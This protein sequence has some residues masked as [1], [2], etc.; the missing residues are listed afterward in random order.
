V[1]RANSGGLTVIC[2]KICNRNKAGTATAAPATRRQALAGTQCKCHDRL[3]T[4]PP[5]PPALRHEVATARKTCHFHQTTS[6]PTTTSAQAVPCQHRPSAHK[7]VGC[8][9]SNFELKALKPK[10]PS[11][12]QE[13]SHAQDGPDMLQPR[14]PT[15]HHLSQHIRKRPSPLSPPLGCKPI[16]TGLLLLQGTHTPCQPQPQPPLPPPPHTHTHT[17]THM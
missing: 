12:P 8:C 13:P 5:P 3:L 7:L 1:S 11:Q 15:T 10:A 9:P 17:H 6:L 16:K 4:A 14:S 2:G